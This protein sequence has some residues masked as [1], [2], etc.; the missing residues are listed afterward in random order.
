MRENTSREKIVKDILFGTF[1]GNA[2]TR[3]G[4][5]HENIAKEKLEN[6]LKQKIEV[7]GLF[8]DLNLPFL[9]PS[10]DGLIENNSLVEIKCPASAKI[11]TPEEGILMKKIKCC[12]IENGQLHL[13]RNDNYF[14]Q[15]Q[16]QLHI[17]NKTFCYF[18]IWTPRGN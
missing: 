2:A 12:L 5:S 8:V 13:K 16:G 15:V 4:I 7:A 14:Y 6:L 9:A 3:Y 1:N 10:P 17:T 18:C 11:L